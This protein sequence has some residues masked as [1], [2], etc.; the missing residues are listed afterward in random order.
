MSLQVICN[1]PNLFAA[2]WHLHLTLIQCTISEGKHL[3]IFLT[4]GRKNCI[5][6]FHLISSSK[7]GNP[8]RCNFYQM[9][10]INAVIWSLSCITAKYKTT[11]EKFRNHFLLKKSMNFGRK[12]NKQKKY[13]KKC[14]GYWSSNSSVTHTM[15]KHSSA[16]FSLPLIQSP[17]MFTNSPAKMWQ[18]ESF[19]WISKLFKDSSI[20]WQQESRIKLQSKSWWEESLTVISGLCTLKPAQETVYYLISWVQYIH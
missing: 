8:K 17:K 3:L 10:L 1:L 9:L 15:T 4:E 6:K 7:K 14:H 12:T 2:T 16:Y 20:C 18:R 19:M 11:L 5:L 13:L